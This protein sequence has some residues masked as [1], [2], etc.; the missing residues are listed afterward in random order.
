M[1][2]FTKEELEDI[3]KKLIENPNRETLKGLNEKYNG[4]SEPSTLSKRI[5]NNEEFIPAMPEVIPTAVVEEPMKNEALNVMPT[6]SIRV[7][8]PVG[9]SIPV[10]EDKQLVEQHPIVEEQQ[11]VNKVPN[12]FVP[13][14]EPSETKSDLVSNNVV[15]EIPNFELPKLET[16]VVSNQNNEPI[17]FTGNLFET[18]PSVANLMQTTD[19]FNSVPNTMPTTEVPVSGTP[20]FGPHIAPENN[21]IPVGGPIN[22]MPVNEPSMFGQM[23]QNYM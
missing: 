4:S 7:E 17:N 1:K 19:N 10:L 8:S 6:P 23:Q 12:Y 16:H 2:Y 20:F 14:V 22:N 15:Q 18:G 5:T 9:A 21:P 13:T 11:A 3:T